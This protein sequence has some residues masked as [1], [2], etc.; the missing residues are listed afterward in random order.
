[1]RFLPPERRVRK[2]DF[3]HIKPTT[4]AIILEETC[5]VH[6]SRTDA[7]LSGIRGGLSLNS[8]V[9]AGSFL[10]C[11]RLQLRLPVM[12]PQ[13]RIVNRCSHNH[14]ILRPRTMKIHHEF[15]LAG[16]VGSSSQLGH[17]A[18]RPYPFP[19]TIPMQPQACSPGNTNPK[20]QSPMK[21]LASKH[22][23]LPIYH[24]L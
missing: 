18:E 5:T 20:T 8:L 24:P 15:F 13:L 17:V 2:T 14:P 22:S 4:E 7:G 1:M 6:H 19:S 21:R 9:S 16:L 12:H 11:N 3:P 10:R 23:N